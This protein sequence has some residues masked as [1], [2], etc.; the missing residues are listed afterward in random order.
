MQHD[1]V[2]RRGADQVS[3]VSE[4]GVASARVCS[5]ASCGPMFTIAAWEIAAQE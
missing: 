5:S 3:A 2:Q 4:C 1:C